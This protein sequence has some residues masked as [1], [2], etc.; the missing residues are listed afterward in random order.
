MVEV[1]QSDVVT[2]D[3]KLGRVLSVSGS[4]TTDDTVGFVV[5]FDIVFSL[6][7][8]RIY[9]LIMNHME[10]KQ[11]IMFVLFILLGSIIES[12]NPVGITG[13]GHN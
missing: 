4:R 9:E 5:C 12:D 6:F 7:M 13:E 2:S 10:L 3:G 1:Y 8:G 11:T